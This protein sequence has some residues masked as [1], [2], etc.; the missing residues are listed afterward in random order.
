MVHLQ[1]IF[2]HLAHQKGTKIGPD[3]SLY[4]KNR[5]KNGIKT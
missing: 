2:F 1:E 4:G 5:V 3:G